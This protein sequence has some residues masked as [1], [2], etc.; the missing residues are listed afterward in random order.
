MKF[1]YESCSSNMKLDMLMQS[2]NFAKFSIK[3]I[4]KKLNVE[5]CVHFVMLDDYFDD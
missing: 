2:M 1:T 4:R 5:F 3:V